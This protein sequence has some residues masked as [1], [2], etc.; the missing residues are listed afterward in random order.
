MLF[1]QYGIVA[2]IVVYK[3]LTIVSMIMYITGYVRVLII[4]IALT[5]SDNTQMGVSYERKR[6]V[7]NDASGMCYFKV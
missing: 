5:D 3:Q 2:L 4:F 6:K 7:N 1:C